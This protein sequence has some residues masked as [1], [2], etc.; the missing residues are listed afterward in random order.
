MRKRLAPAS[1]KVHFPFHLVHV[2][3]GLH[4]VRHSASNIGVE[5]VLGDVPLQVLILGHGIGS[6]GG[7]NP[8]IL[9]FDE[10]LVPTHL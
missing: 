9:L 8:A 4:N 3:V 10:E 6:I 1:W 7:A 5:H 2:T